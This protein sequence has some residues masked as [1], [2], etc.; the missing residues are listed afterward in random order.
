M[1]AV[2]G[3]ESIVREENPP[4]PGCI[5][6]L[7]ML[8]APC[9][10]QLQSSS[11]FGENLNR[12]LARLLSLC[13]RSASINPQAKLRT[14]ILS[15]SPRHWLL[16]LQLQV[17]RIKHPS[18]INTNGGTKGKKGLFKSKLLCFSSRLKISG[19]NIKTFAADQI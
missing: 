18:Y 5:Q 6:K 12:R 1:H 9:C 11:A 15:F 16:A 7:I 4:V 19:S 8:L 10:R 2:S 13:R 17:V 14:R 3:E